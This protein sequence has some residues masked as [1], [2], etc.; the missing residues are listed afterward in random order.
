MKDAISL[1]RANLLHPM[2]RQQVIDTI[3]QIEANSLPKN[4]CVRIVQGLRTKAEQ[5]AIYAQGRTTPGHIVTNARFGQSYHCFGLA[6][7]GALMYDKDNNGTYEI[8][9]WDVHLDQDKDGIADWQEVVQAFTK[10]GYTWGG[11]FHSLPDYPHLEQTFGLNWRDMLAKYN[12]GQ[13][14]PGTKYIKIP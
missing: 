7:D 5:D 4:A 10:L 14:I 3:T 6:W 12:A 2:I 8:L 11:S 1:Q 13:F 9:S